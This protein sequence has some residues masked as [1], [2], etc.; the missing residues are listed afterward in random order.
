MAQKPQHDSTDADWFERVSEWPGIA[1]LFVLALI[2][3][4]FKL[5]G[6]LFALVWKWLLVGF[7]AGAFF[8]WVTHV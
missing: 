8:Y 1:A 3:G 4:V 5:I 6:V 7:L 2:V